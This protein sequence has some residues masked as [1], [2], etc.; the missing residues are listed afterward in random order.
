LAGNSGLRFGDLVLANFSTLPN[1]NGLSVRQFLGD[2]NVALGGDPSIYSIAD[3]NPIAAGLNGSFGEGAVSTFA[4]D[5]LLA[6]AAVD[7]ATAPLPG[8][9]TPFVVLLCIAWALNRRG[10]RRADSRTE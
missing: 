10:Q 4:Q 1:L 9:V 3:L 5:H 8:G 2:V 6:P 7:T